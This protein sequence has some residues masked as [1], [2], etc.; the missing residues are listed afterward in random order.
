MRIPVLTAAMLAIVAALSPLIAQAPTR[1]IIVLLHGRGQ[2]DRD[3]ATV[4]QQWR[5]SLA[6]GFRT[7][8]LQRLR[9]TRTFASCGTRTC[10]AHSPT[11]AA[12]TT[13]PIHDPASCGPG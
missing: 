9:M 12:S 4:D 1:P 3:S 8:T 6:D 10:S 7:L 13:R 5:Q 11:M 2:L